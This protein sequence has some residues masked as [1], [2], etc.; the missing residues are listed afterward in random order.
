MKRIAHVTVVG[1]RSLAES[2]ILAGGGVLVE[3]RNGALERF[4][5]DP[6]L[7]CERGEIGPRLR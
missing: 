2:R 6:E 3:S 7:L 5:F 1:A 4:R